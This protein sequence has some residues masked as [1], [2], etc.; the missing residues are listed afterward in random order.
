LIACA[1]CSSGVQRREEGSVDPTAI[2]LLAAGDLNR[3]HGLGPLE[4][5]KL[6]ACVGAR[7]GQ[8][9]ARFRR[10]LAVVD[11]FRAAPGGPEV[12][13]CWTL[14]GEKVMLVEVR[15]APAPEAAALLADLGPPGAS[16]VYSNSER[17]A[18]SLPV[19]QGGSIEEAIYGDR[20]LAVAVVRAP[21]ATGVV[22]R[23]SGFHPSS[24]QQ[25]L[26]EFVRFETEAF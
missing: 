5:G 2:C 6:P 25:Y 9:T 22:A 11:T 1:A 10:F 13:V 23:I 17:V 8:A 14:N 24:P 4:R 19:P 15:P 20:G 3:W 12:R 18:A 26:D 16:H 7:V 21:G